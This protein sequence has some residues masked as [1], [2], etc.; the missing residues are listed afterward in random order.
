MYNIILGFFLCLFIGS[1]TLANDC[2]VSGNC[3]PSIVGKVL[4]TTKNVVTYPVRR[5]KDRISTR[6]YNRQTRKSCESSGCDNV[7]VE[8]ASP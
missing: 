1:A 8:Y 2:L 7:V 4:H 3:R 5:T 6:R